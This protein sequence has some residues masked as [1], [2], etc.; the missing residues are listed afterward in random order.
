M[1]HMTSFRAKK[2][3]WGVDDHFHDY[4]IQTS[5]LH[6]VTTLY[7]HRNCRVGIRW[8]WK[9]DDII[10]QFYVGFANHSVTLAAYKP[11][12]W[13]VF[14]YTFDT[15]VIIFLIKRCNVR[16]P[17]QSQTWFK[18]PP[19]RAETQN[20]FTSRCRYQRRSIFSSRL[21]AYWPAPIQAVAHC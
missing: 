14:F 17:S 7:W 20:R 4:E 5:P 16:W 6:T 10:L 21:A 12:N 11:V 13:A 15:Q 1:A 2:C 19:Q 18:W 3:L 9:S 8:R